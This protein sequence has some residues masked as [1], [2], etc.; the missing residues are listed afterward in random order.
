MDRL[1]VKDPEV[2]NKWR[3]LYDELTDE[4]QRKFADDCEALYPNQT[5]HTHGNFDYLFKEV[6]KPN[7]NVLEIG[8]WKGELARH[9]KQYNYEIWANIELCKAAIDKTV[10]DVGGRYMVLMPDTF[11]WWK[12]EVKDRAPFDVVI[13]SHAIEHFSDQD[14]HGIINHIAGIPVVMFEAPIKEHGDNWDNYGGTHKLEMGWRGVTEAMMAH[15]YKARC[16]ND[17]CYLY[18]L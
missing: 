2:W 13:S 6:L 4:E 17:H 14:L 7:A 15:G 1:D 18:T 12:E 16:I 10:K 5:H 8:G 3:A 9:C 11:R